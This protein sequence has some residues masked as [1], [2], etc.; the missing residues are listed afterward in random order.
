MQ[1]NVHVILCYIL[2]AQGGIPEHMISIHTQ[3]SSLQPAH[4][5]I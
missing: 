5:G 2:A 3:P 4:V 1:C